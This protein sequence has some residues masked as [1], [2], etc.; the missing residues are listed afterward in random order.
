MVFRCYIDVGPTVRI[1]PLTQY[2]IMYFK[3]KRKFMS[4]MLFKSG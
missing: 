4:K 1:Y 2:I 3:S